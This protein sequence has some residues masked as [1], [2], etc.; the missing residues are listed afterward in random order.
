T[1]TFQ[2]QNIRS[3]W[4]PSVKSNCFNPTQLL[5]L[6]YTNTALNILTNLIFAILP[7]FMLRAR[8]AAF[9]KL[10]ILPNYGRTGDFLWDYADL[11]IWVVVECNTSIIAGSLPNLKPLFKQVQGSYGSQG[12]DSHFRSH[13]HSHSRTETTPAARGTNCA[14]C[15]GRTSPSCRRWVAAIPIGSLT[16]PRGEGRN[17]SEG[18]ILPSEGEG[19]ICV[20]EVRA[21]HS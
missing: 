10:S 12:S 18:R 1:L 20:T 5:Q 3:I 2:C 4:D 14:P 6:S 21:S 7:A 11:T 9:V 15:R 17:S 13:S 16:Y 8:A 19:I